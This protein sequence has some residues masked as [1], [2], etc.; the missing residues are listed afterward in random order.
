MTGLREC[1]TRIYIDKENMIIRYLGKVT[2]VPITND[3][4]KKLAYD[5]REEEYKDRPI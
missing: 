2:E 3:S 5:D 4:S 1:A